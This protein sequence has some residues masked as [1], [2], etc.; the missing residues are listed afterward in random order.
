MNVQTSKV[1]PENQNFSDSKLYEG[2]DKH[3]AISNK[4]IGYIPLE[5]VLGSE[6]KNIELHP[7]NKC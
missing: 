5:S 6:Y 2:L 4:W 7:K 1:E 3:A